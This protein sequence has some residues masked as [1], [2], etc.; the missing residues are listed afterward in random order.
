MALTTEEKIKLD[1]LSFINDGSY[2]EF[3]SDCTK[4]DAPD[5]T[6]LFVGLGGKGCQ[7]VA[8]L[9]A[10]ISRKI[11]C[12]QNGMS[13]NHVE[14]LA[15]DSDDHDLSRLCEENFGEAGSNSVLQNQEVFHLY[16]S[17]LAAVLNN[18]YM[19]PDSIKEWMNESLTIQLIGNGSGGIRQA[20]R[21]LL[22][23]ERNISL[24]CKRISSKLARL[25]TVS[26]KET[27]VYIFAGIGGG[28]GS[29]T[30]IDIPYIIR[31]CAYRLGNKIKIFGY[32]FLPD[33][34][35]V[36]Q[37]MAP[38]IVPNSYAALQEIDVFMELGKGSVRSFKA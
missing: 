14:Y 6:F 20:G 34:Y 36:G 30:V 19:R 11:Q 24:L 15:I 5:G 22:F 32:S 7:V 35:N 4:M 10:E 17:M 28:T 1:K 8:D 31:E 29:G 25:S 33:T 38:H 27:Q 23:G 3:M 13:W 12:S 16:D 26:G 2:S 21:G 18:P 9:K 37:N